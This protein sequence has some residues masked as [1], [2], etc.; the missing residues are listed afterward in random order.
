MTRAHRLV[1]DIE[2]IDGEAPSRH[3]AKHIK[4]AN[5][6]F[7]FFRGCAQLFYSD[8]ASHTIPVPPACFS[9]PLTS[10][11]GDCHTSNFGFLTEEGSHGD[12]VIF[13]PNDFDDACVGYAHWD[14]IRFLTSL[15]L[16][17]THCEEVVNR[18]SSSSEK[19]PVIDSNMVESAQHAFL[20]RYIETCSR[21]TNDA[22]VINEAMEQSPLGKLQ[23]MY[24]K[25]V[26]RAAMGEEFTTKS[27]LAKAVF[28]DD[29]GLSF[30][31]IVD[32]LTP[33]NDVDYA[34]V[35][36]TFSP[37]M[38]DT[39][40]DIVQRENSGTGSVNMQRYYFL[41]GP[42]KP[43]SAHS[44]SHCH[45]VEVKQQREA[46]PLYHFKHLCPVNRLNPAHL[47]ARSQRRMQRRPDL[48]L[49]EV[50]WND[51]HWLIR[52]RHHA[53]VG[54]SPEDIGMGNKAISGSF[55]HFAELCGYTLA[56]AHCRGDRR[57]VRFASEAGPVFQ[58]STQALIKVA[59]R[60]AS[61]TIEDHALFKTLL[62]K[63]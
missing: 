39:V 50:Y 60:Y 40:V 18:A 5:T 30:R 59:N 33:L 10:V 8:L 49:D 20:A 28:M 14:I 1:S 34:L 53:K 44:F 26:K 23:K 55:S 7:T 58:A 48:L 63:S 19:K 56:L 11:M 57:S 12:T 29:D 25:A 16:V 35:S 47:T 32:K 42:A 38:D 6:P 61:Q 52:S 4:M 36:D 22:S 17:K 27:S 62:Q 9:V 13:A 21:V 24:S 41:V 3:V 51:A 43:H 2:R 37:F 31:H 46:A 45:I 15:F 54:I